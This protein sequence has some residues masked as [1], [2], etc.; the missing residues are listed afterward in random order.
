MSASQ[1]APLLAAAVEVRDEHADRAN[2]ATRV[3]TLFGSVIDSVYP[4]E[5][6]AE[7]LGISITNDGAT[8]AATLAGAL[9]ALA[10]AGL[11]GVVKFG[12]GVYPM[13][14]A[15]G[16]AG[17][18]IAWPDG[19]HLKGA[20]MRETVLDFSGSADYFYGSGMFLM[21]GAGR[22]NVQSV[23]ATVAR[24]A[25]MCTVADGSG[26]APN[27]V[28]QLRSTEN[29]VIDDGGTRAE[30]LRVQWVDGNDVYFTTPTVEPYDIG[31]G[32]VQLAKIGFVTG[33][34]SDLT[35]VGKG[36]NPLGVPTPTYTGAIEVN[37]S[38][39][40]SRSDICL[41]IIWGRDLVFSRCRFVG[42][43][44]QP[45]ILES[46]YGAEIAGNTFE[47]DSIKERSQYAIGVYRCTANVRIHHN[48]CVNCRHFVTSGST[49]GTS[50]DYWFGVPNNVTV[51]SNIVL[52]SWQSGIDM[53]RSGYNW[54]ISNNILQ[55]YWAG[56]KIRAQK[57]VVSNNTIYG[58]NPSSDQSDYDAIQ[59]FYDC[60]D[61]T[62]IGNKTYGH[63]CGLRLDAMEADGENII[64]QGNSFADCGAH[65]IRITT[66][67]FTLRRLKIDGNLIDTPTS[68]AISLNGNLEDATV[69]GNTIK[70]GTFGI[71][72]LSGATV[73]GLSVCNNIIRGTA[74]ESL[75]LEDVAGLTCNGNQLYGAN[76][77]GVHARIR[78]CLRGVVS[79]NYVEL[80]A[81]ASG[82][83]AIYINCSGSGTC[84]DLNITG[85]RGH[86]QTSVGTGVAFDAQPNQF[87]YV[88]GNN[89]RTLATS[90]GTA[91]EPTIR[92]LDVP[93]QTLT[94]ASGAV[95]CPHGLKLLQLETE[96]AAAS[97]DLDT[98]SYTGR[99]G[100]RIGVRITNDARNVVLRDA[101]GNL[102]LASDCTL[103]DTNDSITLE[104][105]GSSWS[106]VCRSING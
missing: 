25:V 27:D 17:A 14:L 51:D 64:I 23:T 6:I 50:Q 38:T 71:R 78:D 79:D 104:W 100:D 74:S 37:D 36:I 35:I 59:I 82:G 28:L 46:C 41:R 98:I 32:T 1:K 34:M 33:G 86:A 30:F 96:G 75:Y 22:S 57:V 65:G 72:T 97:D 90:V 26:Y 95:T 63:A 76:A 12:Q 93:R 62:V 3:G 40:A 101:T 102:Q 87:H 58:P 7:N 77:N 66:G 80:P 10:S 4:Q 70:G 39:S 61:I 56:I 31:L 2:T 89:F 5:Y 84:Q 68:L 94:I 55:C 85:N 19:V 43:E 60:N 103:D 54:V 47:F 15:G 20:G 21:Q 18:P 49:S 83:Q 69:N 73:A 53:H 81:G 92:N 67:A 42:V 105:R 106:E 11:K 44:N 16:A 29:Y 9:A 52:G 8:N 45:F 88:D 91:T 24:G 13:T 48:F 99:E